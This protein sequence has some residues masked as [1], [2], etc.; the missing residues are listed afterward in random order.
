MIVEVASIN[1]GNGGYVRVILRRGAEVAICDKIKDWSDEYA[2][3]DVFDEWVECAIGGEEGYTAMVIEGDK[4]I[5]YG[6]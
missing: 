2:N 5:L 6:K 1:D 3:D 4:T